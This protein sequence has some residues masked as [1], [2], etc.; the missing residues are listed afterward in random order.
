MASSLQL[1]SSPRQYRLTATDQQTPSDREQPVE[2][3]QLGKKSLAGVVEDDTQGRALATADRTHPMAHAGAIKS[4]GPLDRTF[5]DREEHRI[6]LPE[7]HHLGA[8]LHARPLF[9]QDELAALEIAAR[10]VQQD[11]HLEREGDIAVEILMQAI[12]PAGPITQ[13]Q[14]R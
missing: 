2:V 14:R 10:L 4:F 6:A 11:R 5:V 7:R 13:D 1:A 3:P 12:V 9:G 8:R